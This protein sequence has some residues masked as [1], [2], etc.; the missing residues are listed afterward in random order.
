[1]TRREL[2]LYPA[3]CIFRLGPSIVL[4]AAVALL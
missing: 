4:T 3:L 1:M 2:P